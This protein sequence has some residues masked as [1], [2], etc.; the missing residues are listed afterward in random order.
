VIRKTL[1]WIDEAA[2]RAQIPDE[3]QAGIGLWD[4]TFAMPYHLFRRELKR[5]A[6]CNLARIEGTLCVSRQEIPAGTVAVPVDDDDWFA[7]ELARVLEQGM[8]DHTGCCW[9]SRFLEVPISLPHQLGHIRQVLFP[10]TQPRWL[11]TSNNYAVVYGSETADQLVGHI[12]ATRWFLAHPS[13]VAHIAQPLRLTN[14]SLASTTQ[15]RP[16]QR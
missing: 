1:D 6:Q 12:R 13:A 15:L 3:M 10:H 8:A 14:R 4:A 5:I 7:P 11:C 16:R 2:F 9:P